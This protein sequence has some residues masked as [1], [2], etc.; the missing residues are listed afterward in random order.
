[1]L[2][3]LDRANHCA[4]CYFLYSIIAVSEIIC[5]EFVRSGQLD[6][7]WPNFILGVKF[8]I[9]IA[10]ILWLCICHFALVKQRAV[11]QSMTPVGK[12][13]PA[14]AIWALNI[15]LVVIVCAP[16]AVIV[17]NF[18][19]LT[20]EYKRVRQV[21]MPVIQF[22]WDLA[23]TCSPA[24]CNA[25]TMVS[26]VLLLTRALHHIDLLVHHTV[27]GLNSYIFFNAFT[28]LLYIPFMYLLFQ[29]FKARRGLDTT[30]RRQLEGVFANTVIE[31]GIILLNFVLVVCASCLV[32]HGG[33]ILN[34]K[35]WLI[36]RIGINS[37]ISTLGNIT[38]FL[39]LDNL[40]RT[41]STN[42]STDISIPELITTT[43]THK[44]DE[45][46]FR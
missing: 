8:T 20:M 38:L 2:I 31:F 24:T 36:L 40:R 6:Q 43:H 10:L 46:T 45:G 18:F 3:Q 21:V 35:F 37:T 15:S 28:F 9:T 14:T 30:L 23:P 1:A 41:N 26:Q 39:I 25:D 16:T 11:C 44:S 7:A 27:A 32:D 29:S 22:L 19:R 33:F 13:L 42:N 34:P 17:T 12:L 4:L 5:E